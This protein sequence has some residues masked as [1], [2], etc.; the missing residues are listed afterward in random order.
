MA[1]EALSGEGLEP[2]RVAAR[3]REPRAVRLGEYI[4]KLLVF[5]DLLIQV[6]PRQAGKAISELFGGRGGKLLAN[7]LRLL[8]GLLPLLLGKGRLGHFAGPSYRGLE[9][10]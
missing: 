3:G 2:P 8:E 7:E 6:P 10:T 4:L 9:D 1:L 5:A